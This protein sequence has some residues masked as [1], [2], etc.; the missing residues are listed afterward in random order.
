MGPQFCISNKFLN[1]AD[2]VVSW[3]TLRELLH[4]IDLD[5]TASLQGKESLM[6]TPIL[7]FH[8]MFICAKS[9][10]ILQQ[11]LTWWIFDIQFVEGSSFVPPKFRFW[12]VTRRS[13]SKDQ[14]TNPGLI[15]ILFF[16]TG[17]ITTATS[18]WHSFFSEQSH[19]LSL[20]TE[21]TV[22]GAIQCSNIFLSVLLIH[23]KN[24]AT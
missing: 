7:Q 4:Y 3:T 20:S 8:I 23:I 16:S 5:V 13:Q 17:F 18:T 12:K 10:Y 6:S 2:S 21:F 9:A 22:N 15:L 19:I 1:T 24:K 11:S 14:V